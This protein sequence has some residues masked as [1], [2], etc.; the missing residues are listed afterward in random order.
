MKAPALPADEAIRL[1]Q[2]RALNILHTPAEER[3]DRLTRLARRLFGVPVALVS[4]LEEDHQW[5]KSVAGPGA[6]TAPR[7]TSFCGHAILQDDVMVVENALE[8][9][10]FHDNP[11]V[12]TSDSP[13]RF[14]AGCPLRTPSGAKVGT[15]CIVDH[16][17]RE[18]N[19][20]DMH[21]LRDLAAMAEAELVAFQ[22]ATSDEL[23]QITNRR[24]F[25][26]LGQLALNECQVKQLPASLTFLDLDRFKAINDT[27]GHREGDRALMDFADAMK[28]SFRH[29]DI[30]ARL[31]GDEFVVLFNGLQHHDAEG[32][33]AR[34]D[35][36]LQKQTQDLDRR[37]ALH[38]SS[39]IVEFDPDQPQSLEQLLEGSD[40]RMYEAK[41][42]KKKL[43][44]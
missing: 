41:N 28:V 2:L 6:A 19:E 20:D 23:T 15:L 33:L 31:G 10:R 44:Q 38:F 29:A 35:H 22:T 27:L 18:F 9:E 5:F 42:G 34:F 7:N 24:G 4:L 12:N 25:M 17:A 30:F 1:A 13:V 3:F 26:T 11:L 36:F 32:V 21:T 16:H 14:Y 8:D 37:Y 40:A 39:G 43:A